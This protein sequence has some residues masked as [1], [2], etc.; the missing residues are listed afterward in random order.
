MSSARWVV[1]LV[2]LL[3]A[4][5]GRVDD[6]SAPDD[7]GPA[8]PEEAG[9]DATEDAFTAPVGHD[10]RA[11]G[12]E[13]QVGGCPFSLGLAPPSDQDCNPSGAPSGDTC[14]LQ[15]A[16]SVYCSQTQGIVNSCSPEGA[17]PDSGGSV[18]NCLNW[19]GYQCVPFEE[20]SGA[21]VWACCA[22]D[23]GNC[24][25]GAPCVP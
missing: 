6:R 16:A 3:A 19:P 17:P 20:P 7:A 4:C 2:P 8:G 1:A 9:R 5:G 22:P 23:S 21:N 12:G 18:E 15:A 24:E 13:C 11:A 25:V 10:C 14:C